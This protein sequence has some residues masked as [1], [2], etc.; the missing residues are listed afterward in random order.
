MLLSDQ[1]LLQSLLVVLKVFKGTLTRAFCSNKLVR[2]A[3][4]SSCV[5]TIKKVVC[6]K[7]LVLRVLTLFSY[8]AGAQVA[9]EAQHETVSVCLE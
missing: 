7:Y 5:L 6:N 3:R 9:N 1:P 4:I 2:F 8:L